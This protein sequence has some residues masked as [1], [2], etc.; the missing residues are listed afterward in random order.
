MY[1]KSYYTFIVIV[2]YY[3]FLQIFNKLSFS[4]NKIQTV[5]Y[6]S[7]IDSLGIAILHLNSNPYLQL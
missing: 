5:N 1:N 4:F 6:C 7:L 2:Y 3:Y